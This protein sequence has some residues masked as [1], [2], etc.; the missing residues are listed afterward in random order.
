MTVSNFLRNWA[1]H[2]IEKPFLYL[3]R[4]NKIKK[5]SIIIRPT[6]YVHSN[7]FTYG[8]DSTTQYQYF[9]VN[10][11]EPICTG[12]LNY[13][14]KEIGDKEAKTRPQYPCLYR[15]YEYDEKKGQFIPINEK[16][17]KDFDC[18]KSSLYRNEQK[19]NLTLEKHYFYCE[20]QASDGDI[21]HFKIEEFW[22]DKKGYL[23]LKNQNLNEVRLFLEPIKDSDE[24]QYVLEIRHYPKLVKIYS[25][26]KLHTEKSKIEETGLTAFTDLGYMGTTDVHEP[27][28][29]GVAAGGFDGAIKIE[30]SILYKFYPEIT[31][32]TYLE[33]EITKN[34]TY[35]EPDFI[36]L[37]DLRQYQLAKVTSAHASQG[38][39]GGWG[40]SKAGFAK[41]KC[42]TKA[43]PENKDIYLNSVLIHSGDEIEWSDTNSPSYE[44]YSDPE[45]R[46]YGHYFSEV[47]QQGHSTLD[48][49]NYYFKGIVGGRD[50]FATMWGNY[51]KKKV[52]NSKWE[53]YTETLKTTII[54]EEWEPWHTWTNQEEYV[55]PFKSDTSMEMSSEGKDTQ[56]IDL[57]YSKIEGPLVRVKVIANNFTIKK[58]VIRNGEVTNLSSIVREEQTG[59]AWA[60][61]ED[62]AGMASWCMDTITKMDPDGSYSKPYKAIGCGKGMPLYIAF[63]QYE[64]TETENFTEDSFFLTQRYE[65]DDP[66]L[67]YES[68]IKRKGKYAD[69]DVTYA[70]YDE[71]KFKLYTEKCN[72]G[73]STIVSFIK[74][75]R[76]GYK[77]YFQQTD[78]YDSDQWLKNREDLN[79]ND[80]TSIV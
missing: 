35:K 36:P 9:Y 73:C 5:G 72:A 10:Y 21:L 23:K 70:K 42:I 40:A 37:Y 49:V 19:F 14:A 28:M 1:L 62:T 54:E 43:P 76:Q 22:L 64:N 47:P 4:R 31:K 63:A 16:G 46:E 66:L 30:P 53:A 38:A 45:T 67:P 55:S 26:F 11:Q 48:P 8:K 12:T 50:S 41:T 69:N 75:T 17:E 2:Y 58:R 79:Q 15:V 27:W 32:V 29:N 24:S 6:S 33:K 71:D 74:S 51:W 56:D 44:R 34:I 52:P 65:G 7:Y 68:P 20:L 18:S 57:E 77:K 59:Y 25:N 39:G 13:E 78:E 60:G 3:P 80:E 61:A